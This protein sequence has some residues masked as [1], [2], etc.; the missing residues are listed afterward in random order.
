[1]LIKMVL[2]RAGGIYSSGKSVMFIAYVIIKNKGIEIQI[3][4]QS[5]FIK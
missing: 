4:M 3:D 5:P 2:N 1:M